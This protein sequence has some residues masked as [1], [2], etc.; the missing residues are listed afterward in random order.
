MPQ[1]I[2]ITFPS[3]P[4]E[5]QSYLAQNG[6]TYIYSASKNQ[7]KR[8][9]EFVRS[10]KV[11]SYAGVAVTTTGSGITTGPTGALI[12][13]VPGFVVPN[14][15]VG[16]DSYKAYRAADSYPNYTEVQVSISSAFSSVAY[17]ATFTGTTHTVPANTLSGKCR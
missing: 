17:A 1:G 4:V 8:G 9:G 15:T 5:G 16:V 7:W 6:F 10:P 2:A 12:Y 3:S 13:N 14:S 11:L